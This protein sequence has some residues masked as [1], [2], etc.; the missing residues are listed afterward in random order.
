MRIVATRVDRSDTVWASA[1]Q[2]FKNHNTAMARN[3]ARKFAF[4]LKKY[5]IA[6]ATTARLYQGKNNWAMNAETRIA[7]NCITNFIN[8]YGWSWVEY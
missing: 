6:N 8:G 3:P 5:P 2:A 7:K 1:H 4:D